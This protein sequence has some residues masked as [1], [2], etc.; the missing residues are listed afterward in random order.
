MSIF[1]ASSHWHPCRSKMTY[2]FIDVC[3]LIVN[4]TRSVMFV[5]DVFHRL[6][7][8]IAIIPDRAIEL[9]AKHLDKIEEGPKAKDI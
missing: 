4:T 1:L 2:I 5:S 8:D 6:T 9:D 7:D 3:A